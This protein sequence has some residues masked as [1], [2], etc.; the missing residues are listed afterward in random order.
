[1]TVE[2]GPGWAAQRPV[3]LM[4]RGVTLSFFV[5]RSFED[6]LEMVT[7]LTDL[8]SANPEAPAQEDVFV[9]WYHNTELGYTQ[10]KMPWAAVR[11]DSISH[12]GP[13]TL[14]MRI[15]IMAAEMV[16]DEVFAQRHLLT[17]AGPRFLLE[18]GTPIRLE[19]DEYVLATAA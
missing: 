17:E 2:M 4:Q 19:S 13:K 7:W 14:R 6:V 5:T 3:D 8:M 16:D 10:C 18:D 11:Y 12:D 9:R 15:S 1:M